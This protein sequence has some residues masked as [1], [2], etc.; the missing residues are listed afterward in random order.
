MGF[1][2][3][4]RHPAKHFRQAEGQYQ[5]GARQIWA[6]AMRVAAIYETPPLPCLSEPWSAAPVLELWEGKPQ[7]LQ[8]QLDDA[9]A[10]KPRQPDDFAQGC[11]RNSDHCRRIYV[12]LQHGSHLSAFQA[13][14]FRLLP[15]AEKDAAR[16]RL[17]VETFHDVR[18]SSRHGVRPTGRRQ[19]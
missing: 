7:H 5:Q 8:N 4:W 10:L 12:N 14:Q 3:P 2:T 11:D 19:C 18:L 9:V 15:Q 13:S 17:G 6:Q 16:I 1:L